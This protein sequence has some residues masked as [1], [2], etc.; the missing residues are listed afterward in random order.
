MTF[1]GPKEVCS[2][3]NIAESTLRK[4]A[5]Y[6][7]KIA[8]YTFAVDQYGHRNYSAGDILVLKQM[9]GLLAKKYTYEDAVNEICNVKNANHANNAEN[10]DETSVLP[11]THATSVPSVLSEELFKEMVTTFHEQAELNKKLV[12]RLERLEERTEKRDLALTQVLRQVLDTRAELAAER[13]K[14]K[15]GWWPWK[16]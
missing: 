13:E 9:Q 6:L 5:I 16:K 8:G 1:Y 12:E 11:I 2:Q 4:W 15:K 10:L 14:G 7:S 3:L